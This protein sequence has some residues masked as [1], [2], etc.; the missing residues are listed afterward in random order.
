MQEEH[1]DDGE[2]QR[3][4]RRVE[5]DAEARGHRGD[6][7]RDGLVRLQQRVADVTHRADEA[8]GRNRPGD[9]ANHRKSG[10]EPI[11][12]GVA[13]C[14]RSLRRIANAARGG[15]TIERAL[16]GAHD[17]HGF[18][19]FGQRFELAGVVLGIFRQHLDAFGDV[20]DLAVEQLALTTDQIRLVADDEHRPH[21]VN[22]LR[23]LFDVLDHQE[24]R[25]LRHV[26][27]VDLHALQLGLR[28]RF[29]LR[30]NPGDVGRMD[31]QDGEDQ[32]KQRPSEL[33]GRLVTAAVLRR[34]GGCCDHESLDPT[35]SR[36]QIST[37]KDTSKSARTC[38]EGMK[39]CGEALSFPLSAP[40]LSAAVFS[41]PG[42]ASAG[43]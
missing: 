3:N 35:R 25:P 18:L 14:L 12:F 38:S 21:E 22:D 43:F 4:E 29:T 39:R 23:F 10:V 33:A 11:G 7:A 6:V 1:Q 27:L 24:E 13:D 34:A 31:R 30:A 16:Q 28:D 5:G 8:D 26:C 42:F 15:E 9:V 17:Q 19:R 2:R 41:S 40:A 20:D 32:R 36:C 37:G